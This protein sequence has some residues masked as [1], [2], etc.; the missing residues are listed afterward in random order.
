MMSS[1]L[2][3]QRRRTRAP[4]RSSI[5]ALVCVAVSV[6]VSTVA[7]ALVQEEAEPPSTEDAHFLMEIT[8]GVGFGALWTLAL[9]AARRARRRAR[10]LSERIS[11]LEE[12]GLMSVRD[13]ATSA[14]HTQLVEKG[15]ADYL[16]GKRVLVAEYGKVNQRLLSHFLREVNARVEL[17]EDG[18]AAVDTALS[19]KRSFDLVLMDVRMPVMSGLDAVREMR[20]SGFSAPIVALTASSRADQRDEIL[21]AGFDELLSKPYQR[22]D[23]MEVLA[24]VAQRF[25]SVVAVGPIVSTLADDE[26][27]TDLIELFLVD[28]RADVGRL[29]RAMQT[30]DMETLAGVAYQIKG[31]AG[32]YG[33]PRLSVQA[34]QLET[35]IVNGLPRERIEAEVQALLRHCAR[36]VSP[37]G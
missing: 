26:D 9:I 35:S 28:L 18:R 20:A 2:C 34:S 22:E 10:E 14:A 19:T 37:I 6:G 7:A 33:Y 23:I 36:I 24:R 11:R 4:F 8:L 30:S 31:C 1:S 17:V 5:L 27:M 13:A 21:Q 3:R 16:E 25:G 29:E 12:R 32:G 15:V